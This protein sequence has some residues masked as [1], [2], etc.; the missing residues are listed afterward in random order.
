MKTFLIVAAL[1]AGAIGIAEA[2]TIIGPQGA[3]N[4]LA[5]SDYGGVDVATISFS[6]ANALLFPGA[7]SIL[8]L[9][10]SSHSSNQDFIVFRATSSLEASAVSAS[11]SFAT[12]DYRTTN[13]FFRV[14]YSSAQ[15]NSGDYNNQYGLTFNYR[16]PAPIRVKAGATAKANVGTMQN[17]LIFFTK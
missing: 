1:M 11:A 15:A 13:E 2:D 10:I 9:A 4:P 16:F 12:A 14:Y 5:T 3:G 8:G 7:G 17:I 6:S